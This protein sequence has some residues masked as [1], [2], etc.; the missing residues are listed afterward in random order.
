MMLVVWLLGHDALGA[1]VLLDLVAVARP[2]RELDGAVAVPA[3]RMHV[4]VPLVDEQLDELKRARL[5]EGGGGGEGGGEE[6]A[7]CE[8]AGERC[9]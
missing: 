6:G 1:Q 4:R 3:L 2:A 7:R 5:G 9:G 8:G